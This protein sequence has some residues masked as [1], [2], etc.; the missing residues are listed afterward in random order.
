MRKFTYS[1]S[2]QNDLLAIGAYTLAM[3]GPQQT[4][5]YLDQLEDCCGLI[6]QNPNM[7][8]PWHGKPDSLRRIEQGKRVIFYWNQDSGI[9]ISRILHQRMIPSHRS[10]EEN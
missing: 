1:T 7:G 6:A 2:A 9:L 5:R 4:A 3:W 10:F 8:R